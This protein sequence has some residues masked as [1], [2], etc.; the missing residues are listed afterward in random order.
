LAFL[1]CRNHGEVVASTC[2]EE[3]ARP[4]ISPGIW[5]GLGWFMWYTLWLCQNSYWKWP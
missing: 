1:N 4:G 5:D 2:L 3:I